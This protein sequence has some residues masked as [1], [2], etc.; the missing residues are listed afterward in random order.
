MIEVENKVKIYDIAGKK[1]TDVSE[2]K[3]TSHW[4]DDRFINIILP[5]FSELKVL[6][7]DLEAAIK[8]ATNTARF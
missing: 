5:G 1:N 7:G 2:I 8:N 4:N 3:I 6:A